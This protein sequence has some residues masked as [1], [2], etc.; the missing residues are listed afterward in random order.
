MRALT[1]RP[2]GVNVIIEWDQR[3]RGEAALDAGVRVI[4]TFWGDPRPY[5][6]LCGQAGA[7]HLHTMGSA[8]QARAVAQGWE[9]GG[10]VLG[11]VATLPLVPAVVDAV[12]PVPVVAAGGIGDGRG[13]AAVL[14][15]GASAGWCG[16][17]FLLAEE[18]AAHEN[19]R[20]AVC[21][22]GET[23][24]ALSE[25]YSLGWPGAPHRTSRPTSRR[26]P[27][28][29]W[30]RSRC[31][32]QARS[33]S[34]STPASPG[35]LSRIRR[36]SRP[37]SGYSPQLRGDDRPTDRPT[38]PAF[39]V[40]S[41]RHH[42]TGRTVHDDHRL[43]PRR[44][45]RRG[46][47]PRRRAHDRDVHGPR[48]SRWMSID[49]PDLTHPHRRRRRLPAAPESSTAGIRACESARHDV[50]GDERGCGH[51]AGDPNRH[52]GRRPG[53][54]CPRSPGRPSP[55]RACSS[56]SRTTCARPQRAPAQ[57]EP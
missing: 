36:R 39:A 25:M 32:A 18:S 12:H 8:E 10:H 34:S 40:Q 35:R 52:A 19:Y 3:A 21:A 42:D 2:F 16:T 28:G 29:H 47:Q 13:L 24:T 48:R 43:R 15:L 38:I 46:Q 11:Q 20:R 17:A 31:R 45:H 33:S 6:A 5:A 50:G 7:V 53:P 9:A 49:S 55:G 14:A 37:R 56:A 51:R 22:A 23:D 30:L 54:R 41:L 27:D 44:L 26:W 57:R 4:S 1:A